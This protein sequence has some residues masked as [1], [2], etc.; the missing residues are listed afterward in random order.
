MNIDSAL[1][2]KHVDLISERCGEEEVMCP[3]G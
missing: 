2:K 3:D 1:F